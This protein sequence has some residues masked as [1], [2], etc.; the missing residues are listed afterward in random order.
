MD[1]WKKEIKE[2]VSYCKEDRRDLWIS[3]ID[4]LSI[5]NFSKLDD[6]RQ[7]AY[8]DQ[9]RSFIKT[10]EIMKTLD[11]GGSWDDVRELL[12][13]GHEYC[14]Y[15]AGIIAHMMLRYSK[16]GIEFTQK[17]FGDTLEFMFPDLKKE[18]DEELEKGNKKALE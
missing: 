10:A 6:L 1:K 13:E 7:Y 3:D 17:S 14:Q 8:D 2:Y 12:M 16:Y 18:F 15:P 9:K 11:E 5:E 4:A